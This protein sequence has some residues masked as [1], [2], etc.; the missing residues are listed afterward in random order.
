M[1][2]LLLFTKDIL[3]NLQ[4]LNLRN[5]SA[6]PNTVPSGTPPR[7]PGPNP[8]ELPRR[9]S[10]EVSI[11]K[12][13]L[14][15]VCCCRICTRQTRRFPCSRDRR[16]WSRRDHR[17]SSLR[18]WR[19]NNLNIFI[20]TFVDSFFLLLDSAGERVPQSGP[21]RVQFTAPSNERRRERKRGA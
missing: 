4:A 2:S 14:K 11:L 6:S 3:E 15:R 7:H 19:W 21:G 17:S 9:V 1:Y 13:E 18:R 10:S 5:S 8:A 20:R 12:L 16:V